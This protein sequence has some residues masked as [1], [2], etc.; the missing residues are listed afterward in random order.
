MDSTGPSLLPS[1]LANRLP[2]AIRAA[3]AGQ[4]EQARTLLLQIV[5]EDENNE[6]AWLWLSGVVETDEDRR[7]CLENVLAL[8]PNNE[9]ARRGLAKLGAGQTAERE[10]L[11]SSVEEGKMNLALPEAQ[12]VRREIT[13]VSPAAA[14]LY[15]ERQVQ[16]WEWRDPTTVVRQVELP[17]FAPESTFDDV[18]NSSKELCAYCAGVL[19][20][21]EKRCSHCGRN[22]MVA[23]YRQEKPSTNMHV[24]WVLLLGAAQLH[25][26][27]G[28]VNFLADPNNL[29]MVILHVIIALVLAGLTFFVYLRHFW[30]YTVSLVFL[31]LLLAFTVLNIINGEAIGEF[32]NQLI[33]NE[34][35]RELAAGVTIPLVA[36]VV[37]LVR[38]LLLAATVLALSCGVFF[39]GPDFARDT[40]REIAEV[41]KGQ[42]FGTDYYGRGQEH[43]KQGRWATAV[44]YFQRASAH[45][46]HQVYYQRALGQAYAVLGFYQRSLDVLESAEK[47]ASNQTLQAEIRALIQRVKE[48]QAKTG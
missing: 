31:S 34:A 12:V 1:S 41:S 4:R 37:G 10:A 25:F 46:P 42:R 13:P 32:I 8:N 43:T 7:V 39:V 15:P 27:Q 48:H 26:A 9:V 47:M 30:A 28:I 21:D 6:L 20:F 33:G 24:F 16:E 23:R 45:E 17:S 14:V 35:T 29:G 3:R 44:L 5:E 18:W 2:E 22:L 19:A 40:T 36:D 11:Y 38:T